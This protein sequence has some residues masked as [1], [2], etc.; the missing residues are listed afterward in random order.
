MKHHYKLMALSSLLISP[1]FAHGTAEPFDINIDNLN[2]ISQDRILLAAADTDVMGQSGGSTPSLLPEDERIDADSLFGTEGGYFHPFISITGEY[3]DNLYNVNT[4]ET[5]NFL[6]RISPGIW[7]SVPSSK[8]PPL[9]L[10][11]SN[12]SAG[13]LQLAL[14][15][16]QSFDRFNAYL[17]GGLDIKFYSEDSDL[18]D[19][20]ALVEGLFQYNLRGGLSFRLVDR[21]THAQDQFDIGNATSVD[22]MRRYDSNITLLAAD[23]DLSEKFRTKVEYSNFWLSYDDTIDEFLNRMDNGIS[24]YAIYKYSVKTAFFLEYRYVDISYDTADVKDSKD[25]YLYGGITWDST[26]KTSL[27][28]KGGYQDKQYKEDSFSE[29]DRTGLAME[30]AL[31]YQYSTKTS[32]TLALSHKIEESD[33]SLALNKKVFTGALYYYQD[34]TDRL[35]GV[36]VFSYSNEAYDQIAG[37]PER[38]DDSFFVKPSLQYT[39]KDWLMAEL[40]YSYDTRNSTDNFFDYDTNTVY[41]SLNSAL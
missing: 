36:C 22:N 16:T 6:T 3:T 4:D 39:L 25:N 20:D 41:L 2:V 33:S 18:N 32:L 14:P 29:Y 11:P 8:E 37:A 9:N 1:T 12:T 19:T 21:F 7:L 35:K 10:N 27:S 26:E 5:N 38:T 30:M 13:G 34:F 23:W 17:L 24:A 40:A 31:D 28:L 15:S